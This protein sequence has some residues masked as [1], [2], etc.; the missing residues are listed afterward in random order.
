MVLFA[1]RQP[2]IA[3]RLVRLVLTRVPGPPG[4]TMTVGNVRAD[5]TSRIELTG[6]AI[7]RGDTLLA[8]VD[9]VRATYNLLSLLGG[10]LRVRELEVAGIVVTGA[11]PTRAPGAR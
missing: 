8:A 6:L 3:T 5:W 10:R 7:T 9:T 11:S 4:A 1:V 2:P